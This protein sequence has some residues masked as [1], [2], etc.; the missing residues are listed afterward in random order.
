MEI[1]DNL[2]L[3]LQT[4]LSLTNLAYCLLGV[5]LGTAI[6]VLPGLGPASH[7][8]NAAANDIR[9]SRGISFDHACWHLLWRPV[10]RLH[11]RYPREP[12]RRNIL[13][14]HRFGRL[15]DGP[16]RASWPGTRGSGNRVILRRHGGDR[17]HRSIRA[18]A[19]P[20]GA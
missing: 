9:S 18:A 5:F 7:D 10:W 19:R 2:F 14:H 12:A 1:L 13:R 8:R 16:A 3:G 6:G 11:D 20:V 15:S 4:A 17:P